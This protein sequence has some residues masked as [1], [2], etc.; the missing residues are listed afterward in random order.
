MKH[1]DRQKEGRAETPSSSVFIC[2]R[3]ANNAYILNILGCSIQHLLNTL[4]ENDILNYF[5][6]I[7]WRFETSVVADSL[8]V[9]NT[10]QPQREKLR[11]IWGL[12]LV[13]GTWNQSLIAACYKCLQCVRACVRVGVGVG[14]GSGPTNGS[15][16]LHLHISMSARLHPLPDRIIGILS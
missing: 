4:W 15:V 16:D 10:S 13:T 1:A 5:I 3:C 14:V 7:T 12:L 2:A 8:L 11:E 6:D 9:L